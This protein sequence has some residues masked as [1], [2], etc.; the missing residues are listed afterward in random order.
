MHDDAW[1][2]RW[3]SI[4][5]SSLVDLVLRRRGPL[6]VGRRRPMRPGTL[7]RR[8]ANISVLRERK[9]ERERERERERR[10]MRER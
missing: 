2:H 1:L 10:E 9:R 4:S 3:A 5:S 8:D 7:T 6:D